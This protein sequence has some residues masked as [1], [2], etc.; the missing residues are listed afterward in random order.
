MIYTA[1]QYQKNCVD[2]ILKNSKCGLF[3][4]MGLGKSSI[5]LTALE[6]LHNTFELN[7]TLIIAPKRVA[8]HT[9]TSEQEKWDHLQSIKISR[10]IGS[11][12]QRISALRTEADIYLI[13]RDNIAWLVQY[14][15]AILKKWPFDCLVVDESSSFKNRASMRFKA[16]RKVLPRLKRVVI[17]TGTPAAQSLLDLWP[18]LY[19]L[20]QGERLGRTFTGY[21]DTYF[22]AAAQNGH[23]VFKYELKEGAEAQIHDKIKDLCLSMTAK[24]YLDLPE[25]IDVFEEVVLENYDKYIE[26]KKKETLLLANGEELTPINAA[27]LYGVL[28]QFAN[29]AVYTGVDKEYEVVDNTKLDALVEDVEALNGS[30]ILIFYQFISD[31]ERI[32]KRIP[33]AV[34][35]TDTKQI[36]E[37]NAGKIPVLVLN[38]LSAGHGLNMQEGGNTIA[39]YG[40]PFSLEI[41]MQSNARIHRQGLLRPVTIKHYIAKGTVEEVVLAGLGD[42]AMTQDK[43]IEALKR[44]L[45]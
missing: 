45:L 8:E 34:A 9:W 29:G 42:K 1:H 24:D 5:T 3:I 43:L 2:H 12:K 40:L 27:S 11:E 26:F 28:L 30:P 23:I 7:K 19:L 38:G 4:G 44:H 33:Q 25:R 22:R 21:K 14:C 16:V 37:W 31:K 41:Y 6:Y 13:S 17:L 35:F 32:L 10:I 39:W 36:D 15:Q 20:D 18:Q